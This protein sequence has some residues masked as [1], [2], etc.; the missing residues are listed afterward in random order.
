[1]EDP[2]IVAERIISNVENVI[3]GKQ[4]ELR[5]AVTALLCGGHMLIEDVP[6]YRRWRSKTG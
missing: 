2:K 6:S 4:S 3:V 1:V 5:L